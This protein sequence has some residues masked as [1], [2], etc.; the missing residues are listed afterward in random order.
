MIKFDV[1][2]HLDTQ[3]LKSKT[4]SSHHAAQMQLDQDVLKDSN[5]FIPMDTGELMRSGIR[6]TQ[7]GSGRIVWNTPYAR[8]LYYNPQYDFSHDVNPNAGGL[9]FERA[10]SIH[11]KDWLKDAKKQYARYFDG[12]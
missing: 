5:Y 9:W 6:H 3:K 1:K 2:T 7:I 11:K 12:K 10:K 8:R 4:K